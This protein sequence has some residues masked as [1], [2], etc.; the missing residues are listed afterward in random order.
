MVIYQILLFL[1]LIAYLPWTTIWWGRPGNKANVGNVVVYQ[2]IQLEIQ[3][4]IQAVL[5]QLCANL[6]ITCN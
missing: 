2:Q 1:H 5:T 4:E 6:D 3:L